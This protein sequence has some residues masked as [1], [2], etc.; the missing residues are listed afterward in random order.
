MAQKRLRTPALNHVDKLQ[1]W[2]K[3]DVEKRIFYV[4]TNDKFEVGHFLQ[5][6]GAILPII[7]SNRQ[8]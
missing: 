8:Q 6:L 1:F 4:K 5:D 3:S 7:V 2:S